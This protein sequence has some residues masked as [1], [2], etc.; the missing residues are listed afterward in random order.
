MSSKAPVK[1]KP[2]AAPAAAA[3][4]K[5]ATTTIGKTSAAAKPAGKSTTGTVKK[6]AGAAAKPGAATAAKGKAG[7]V[8]KPAAGA[9]G[10]KGK[11]GAAAGGPKKETP[12]QIKQREEAEAK[13]REEQERAEAEAE[14]LREE[15]QER[16]REEQERKRLE[17]EAAIKEEEERIQKK[18]AEQQKKEREFR[19]AQK[20]Y[21]EAAFDDEIDEILKI[22]KLSSKDVPKDPGCYLSSLLKNQWDC[23]PVETEDEKGTTSLSEAACAGNYDIVK[24]LLELGANPNKENDQ[25]RTPLWRASFMGKPE[26]AK[27]LL[28]YGGDPTII[29]GDG[30][31]A[32]SCANNDEVKAIFASWQ[33]ENVDNVKT[34]G[35]QEKITKEREGNWKAPVLPD[36]KPPENGFSMQITIKGLSHGLESIETSGRYP[37]IVDVAG[38]ASMFLKYR[39]TNY[40]SILKME[41]ME[42]EYIRK[43]LLGATRYGKPLVF[44]MADLKPDPEV[45]TQY[46]DKIR[47]GLLADIISMDYIKKEMYFDLTKEEDGEEFRQFKFDPLYLAH[48]KLIIMT[49]QVLDIPDWFMDRLFTVKVA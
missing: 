4:S 48:F 45:V 11:A 23:V 49:H 7:A 20:T 19:K 32:L 22:L 37:F 1:K 2:A 6:P 5:T 14:R 40:L 31:T 21:L 27:I 13:A 46:F 29:A 8:K 12:E 15:E 25:R 36:F 9:G 35:I 3:K 17:V 39:D 41:D 30:E 26:C 44:D 28:E 18:E 10:A 42:P 34:L 33:E 24:L 38:N 16:I 43:A 47:P